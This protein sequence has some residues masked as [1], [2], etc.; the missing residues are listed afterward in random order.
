MKKYIVVAGNIGVGKSTL[1]RLLC[2]KINW[3]PFYEPVAENP[4]LADFYENME[5]W[6]FHSQVF[7]LAHRLKIMQSVIQ[8]PGPVIQD[9]SIFEDAEIF[10]YNLYLQGHFSQRDWETYQ[11]LYQSIKDF[12]PPP[13][14]VIYLRAS[15]STLIHR[16]QQRSRDYEKSISPEYLQN[17]NNL[18]RQWIDHFTYCPVL[19][20][21]A[22]DLDYVAHP[23]HL[24]LIVKKVQEKLT[25]KDVVIFE[26]DEVAQAGE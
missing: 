26:P 15:V 17:L 25:G 1:V 11:S 12:L 13:D 2:E 4:Y 22:D 10:A 23:H 16:I 6:S 7:F 14:L 5:A 3:E 24:D 20:V 8:H 9:R 18:Y 19:T 21:P